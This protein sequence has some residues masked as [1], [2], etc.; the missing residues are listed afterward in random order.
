[1]KIHIISINDTQI[2]IYKK[3]DFHLNIKEVCTAFQPFVQ[4]GDL[5]YLDNIDCQPNGEAYIKVMD[6]IVWATDWDD[7]LP[8]PK[9]NLMKLTQKLKDDF[10]IFLSEHQQYQAQKL[11]KLQEAIHNIEKRKAL[12]ADSEEAIFDDLKKIQKINNCT[13]ENYIETKKDIY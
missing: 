2:N 6:F 1:M 12:I 3:I 8:I 7:L 5:D 11:E 4:I 13:Y 9:S 10:L